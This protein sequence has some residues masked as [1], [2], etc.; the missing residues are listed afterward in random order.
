M[1]SSQKSS[2]QEISGRKPKKKGLTNLSCTVS[3]IHKCIVKSQLELHI[4]F[5]LML[6]VE[7]VDQT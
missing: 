2:T 1:T 6:I 4:I 5:S 7:E 3:T